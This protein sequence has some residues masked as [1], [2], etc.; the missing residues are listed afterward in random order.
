MNEERTETKSPKGCFV[1]CS[2]PS[3]RLWCDKSVCRQKVDGWRNEVSGEVH[4]YIKYSS[5]NNILCHMTGLIFKEGFPFLIFCTCTH[6]SNRA[7][8]K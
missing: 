2:C 8:S 7:S 1:C 4:V 6:D 5:S 3:L